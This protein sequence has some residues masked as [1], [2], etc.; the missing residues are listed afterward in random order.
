M[1]TLILSLVFIGV[2]YDQWK[3]TTH[4]EDLRSRP[5][6]GLLQHILQL[7]YNRAV[8]EPDRLNQ[9]EPFSPEVSRII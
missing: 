6:N 2:M 5:S 1:Q 8:T 9:Y 4:E 3:G 7:C